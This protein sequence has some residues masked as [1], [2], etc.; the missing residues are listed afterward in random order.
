MLSSP[1]RSAFS[2]IDATHA[3]VWND[4][5]SPDKYELRAGNGRPYKSADALQYDL[6]ANSVLAVELSRG[7]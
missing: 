7:K 1:Q 6:L 4:S 5:S 2:L 3:N